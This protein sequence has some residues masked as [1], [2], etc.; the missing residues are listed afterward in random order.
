M[1][2]GSTEL[3]EIFK[4]FDVE[5]IST[6]RKQYKRKEGYKERAVRFYI[7][8]RADAKKVTLDDLKKYAEELRSKYPE[9]QFVV[10]QEGNFYVLTKKSGKKPTIPIY[11][12]LENQRFFVR[13]DDVL[14]NRSLTN[15]LI[16]VTLGALGVS[17]N[18]YGGVA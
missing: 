1:M 6:T 12:D 14:N 17:T 4:D 11:F 15:Y 3:V 13:K 18:K 5:V 2:V 16:M 8:K 10:E 7:V 9:E